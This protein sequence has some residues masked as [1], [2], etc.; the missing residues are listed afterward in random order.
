M[1]EFGA[2]PGIYDTSPCLSL[3]SR[4]TGDGYSEPCT[5]LW[6]AMLKIG[7]F[8]LVLNSELLRIKVKP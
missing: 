8:L 7:A 3:R 4:Y 5:M 2:I 6:K 1:S